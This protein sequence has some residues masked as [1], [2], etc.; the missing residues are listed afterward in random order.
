MAFGVCTLDY[1][2]K[3][4][5][6]YK[7]WEEQFRRHAYVWLFTRRGKKTMDIHTGCEYCLLEKKKIISLFQSKSNFQENHTKSSSR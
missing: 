4:M 6:R 3:A 1:M 5:V 7:L 2:H